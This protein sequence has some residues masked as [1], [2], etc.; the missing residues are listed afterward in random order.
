[1]GVYLMGR[2]NKIA[3]ASPSKTGHSKGRKR[4]VGISFLALLLILLSTGLGGCTPAAVTP[5]VTPPPPPPTAAIPTATS[6]PPTATAK[7][8][9]TATLAPTAV[10]TPAMVEYTVEAGDNLHTIAEQF[11]VTGEEIMKANNIE[12]ADLIVIGQKLKI[13]KKQ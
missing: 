10:P 11:G 1:M 12:N 7:P 2:N 13:P 3:V 5:T 8:A 6:V 9:P 4:A